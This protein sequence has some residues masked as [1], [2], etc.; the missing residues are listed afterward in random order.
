MPS[1][2]FGV[3]IES[4]LSV[5]LSTGLTVFEV[6]HPMVS[7]D[8]RRRPNGILLVDV[9]FE[10]RL[11]N[12]YVLGEHGTQNEVTRLPQAPLA[13]SQPSVAGC[14]VHGSLP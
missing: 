5:V 1:S 2:P 9:D 3:F 12:L 11:S 10:Q 6:P 7:I 4:F 14:R 8:I 13:H